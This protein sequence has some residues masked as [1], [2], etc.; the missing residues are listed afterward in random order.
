[1]SDDLDDLWL[2]VSP[3][4]KFIGANGE[5]GASPAQ[6]TCLLAAGVH[7]VAA[8]ERAASASLGVLGKPLHR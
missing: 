8:L 5:A 1:M 6:G 3:K 2:F 7:G 4:L